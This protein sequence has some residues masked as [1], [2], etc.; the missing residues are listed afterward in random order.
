MA[1]AARPKGQHCGKESKVEDL[2][3]VTGDSRALAERPYLE[4]LPS[5]TACPLDD[6]PSEALRAEREREKERASE[7]GSLLC[8]EEAAPSKK[9]GRRLAQNEEFVGRKLRSAQSEAGQKKEELR[10]K[11]TA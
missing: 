8:G 7:G 4:L 10:S 9:E 3:N 11:K 5:S 1:K 6:V 2:D